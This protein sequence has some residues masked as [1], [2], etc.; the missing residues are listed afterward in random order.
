MKLDEFDLDPRELATLLSGTRF[1]L[2][3]L[4]FLM[5]S[6]SAKLW[7]D[8]GGDSSAAVVASRGM[9]A[10]DMALGLGGLLA[11]ANDKPARGW[12]EAAAFSDLMDTVSTAMSFRRLPRGRALLMGATAAGAAMLGMQLAPLLDD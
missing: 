11:L 6:R 3:A 9:G 4:L 1:A 12:I 2:G 10:R 5:P 8:E 7:S